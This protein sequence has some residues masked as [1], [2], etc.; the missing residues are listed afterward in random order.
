[1]AFHCSLL[2]SRPVGL[3]ADA[4]RRMISPS[5]P[6]LSNLAT[7]PSKSNNRVAG[8]KYGYLARLTPARSQIVSWF[9]HDGSDS[10]TCRGFMMWDRNSAPRWLAPVPATVCT[11]A[12]RSMAFSLPSLPWKFNST[13]RARRTKAM[14]PSMAVYSWRKGLSSSRRR[15]SASRTTGSGH[16]LPSSVRKTPTPRLAFWGCVS[17]KNSR[18]RSKISSVATGPRV[19]RTVMFGFDCVKY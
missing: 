7:M 11:D 15:F 14:S 12:I 18:F 13:S 19:L 8:L 16:G 2:G 4:C 3:C 6:S 10:H 17:L 9:A 5:W 1:M